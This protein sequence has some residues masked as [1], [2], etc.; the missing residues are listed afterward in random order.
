[1]TQGCSLSPILFSV[2]IIKEVEQAEPG[3]QL[4]SGKEVGGML[5][6]MIEPAEAY[7][8]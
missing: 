8:Y 2:Y 1:M 6:A 7:G 4:N 3:V 5:F